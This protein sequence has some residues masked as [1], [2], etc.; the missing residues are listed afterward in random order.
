MALNRLLWLLIVNVK[1]F[2]SALNGW[3]IP[4]IN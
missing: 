2:F 3:E 1:L 4:P